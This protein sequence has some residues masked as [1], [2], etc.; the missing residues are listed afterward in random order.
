MEEKTLNK[1]FRSSLLAL[2]LLQASCGTLPNRIV[3]F[4]PGSCQNM[5]EENLLAS[6]DELGSSSTT[7]TLQCAMTTARSANTKALLMSPLPARIA[8]H[9]AER[10]PPGTD[11]EALASEG[12]SLAERA[13]TSGGE[14]DAATHYYLA[15]NLG[16]A[17]N[18]HP[19]QAAENI[20]R[21]ESELTRAVQLS[22][23]IDDGGPLRLLGM[24]Y[25]KA[26]PWPTGIGDG[27]KALS[28][29][30][31]AVSSYPGH[32][33]NH[34]FYAEALFEVDDQK[35]E[36]QKEIKKGTQLLNEGQWGFNRVVWQKEFADVVREIS[37]GR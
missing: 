14:G 18:D 13:I 22:K 4:K 36:A 2:V 20:Q 8:L 35:P 26:P 34:L 33:L 15:A 37:G 11:R 9:L 32:P 21:L 16:L 31:E 30:K 7:E 28:Y 12:V 25:L 27:D 1:P 6:A 23:G 5:T 3:T 24:L 10:Q 19:V 17:I 29:L